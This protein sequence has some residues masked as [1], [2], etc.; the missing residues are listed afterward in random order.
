ME[1]WYNIFFFFIAIVGG[2]FIVELLKKI[3]RV[4]LDSEIGVKERSVRLSIAIGYLE[5]AIVFILVCTGHFDGIGWLFAAKSIA[6]FRE[7]ENRFFTEYYLVG[8][9]ASILWAM[10]CALAVKW[11]VAISI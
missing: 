10:I 3:L 5:R 11:L 4:Y 7:L 1:T 8:S 9:L 2:S 6:R